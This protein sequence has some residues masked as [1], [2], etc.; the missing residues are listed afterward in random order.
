MMRTIPAHVVG[1]TVFV[2]AVELYSPWPQITGNKRAGRQVQSK[3]PKRK[4]LRLHSLLLTTGELD[5]KT[6]DSAS[7]LLTIGWKYLR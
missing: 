7:L 3:T 4:E 6:E 2:S 1:F 5:Y